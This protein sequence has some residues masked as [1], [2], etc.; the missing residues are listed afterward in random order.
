[1]RG[2]WFFVVLLCLVCGGRN[3]SV[4]AYQ[5]ITMSKVR[6]TPP[7][8]RA[9][10]SGVMANPPREYFPV[11]SNP[12]FKITDVFV[13]PDE[14][15]TFVVYVGFPES[16]HGA[17]HT[18]F[19][20]ELF[21]SRY[22]SV[23][24][25]E[26]RY[27]Q[28]R[29]PFVC[30]WKL[31]ISI[32]GHEQ[33]RAFR[34]PN[35]EIQYQ[36]NVRGGARYFETV[37]MECKVPRLIVTQHMIRSTVDLVYYNVDSEPEKRDAFRRAATEGRLNILNIQYAWSQE[38]M[39]KEESI[40][41]SSSLRVDEEPFSL[42]ICTMAYRVDHFLPEWVAYHNLLGFEKIYIYDDSGRR[43]TSTHLLLQYWIKKGLVEYIPWPQTPK[44]TK[45]Y[46]P[47]QIQGM[48]SCLRRFGKRHHFVFIG[49]ADEF[50]VPAISLRLRDRA[51]HN[52]KPLVAGKTIMEI[53]KNRMFGL[54]MMA[55]A[56]MSIKNIDVGG[57]HQD[58]LSGKSLILGA[59]DR[60]CAKGVTEDREKTFFF[61][62]QGNLSVFPI[63]DQG[64][65]IVIGSSQSLPRAAHP[66][67]VRLHHHWSPTADRGCPYVD[68]DAIEALL[69]SHDPG[70]DFSDNSF[71]WVHTSPRSL[72]PLLADMLQVSGE[73]K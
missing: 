18:R 27:G 51:E 4:T 42:A 46:F 16:S 37:V 40:I 39:K 67:V 66:D 73:T 33:T 70:E 23:G 21:S 63:V 48:N 56:S 15:M 55:N 53:A 47:R 12:E 11:N 30:N 68:F 38:E 2:N 52:M 17:Y 10:G 64:H 44:R 35:D 71:T 41:A 8:V 45:V 19:F 14:W 60:V 59:A 24:D 61:T 72:H 32:G 62:N 22:E 58:A 5:T 54:L 20:N 50:I 31:P 1:M 65:N 7:M 34:S 43:P 29:S 25:D 28:V 57:Q 6:P 69:K 13:S 9:A 3:A 49:D 26:R 36:Q